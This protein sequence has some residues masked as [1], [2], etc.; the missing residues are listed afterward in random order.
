M[1]MYGDLMAPGVAKDGPLSDES[2]GAPWGEVIRNYEPKPGVSWRFGRPNYARVNK[3]YFAGRTKIHAEGSLESVV[4]TIVKNWEVDSH[5]VLK[6]SDWKTMNTDKFLISVNGGPKAN[7]QALADVG[8]YNALIADIPGKYAGSQETFESANKIWSEV[9]TEGFAWELLEVYSGPPSVTFSWR[10][11]GKF[12][13]KYTDK[14]GREYAPT[15]EIVN[16]QGI[17]IARVDD[18][19]MI[20]ELEVFYNPLDVIDPLLKIPIAKPPPSSSGCSVM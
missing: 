11:F 14:N 19:L 5:H 12:T 2:M 4:Q 6:P 10:H 1:A 15:N 16:L 13:G 18:N 7:A 9:F 20:D 17:C 3:S 8:P